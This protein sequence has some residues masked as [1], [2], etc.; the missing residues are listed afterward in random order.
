MTYGTFKAG[1]TISQM[2]KGGEVNPLPAAI[3]TGGTVGVIP[4]VPVNNAVIAERV[5]FLL[6]QCGFQETKL[7]HIL[8][9]LVLALRYLEIQIGNPSDQLGIAYCLGKF[10]QAFERGQT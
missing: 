8:G 10:S 5:L 9:R 1:F 6:L 7:G 2:R 3:I 4:L